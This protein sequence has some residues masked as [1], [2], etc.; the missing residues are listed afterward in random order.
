MKNKDKI[1][2]LLEQLLVEL[3]SDDTPVKRKRGRPKKEKVILP[4]HKETEDVPYVPY[5]QPKLDEIP[6]ETLQ[7]KPLK[8]KKKEQVVGT[9]AKIRQRTGRD[10]KGTAAHRQ[11]LTV[12]KGG[13]PNLFELSSDFH[14]HKDDVKIDKLLTKGKQ[15]TPRMN[16]VRTRVDVDCIG[17]GETCSVHPDEVGM[18]GRYRCMDCI[19]TGN[20]VDDDEDYEVLEDDN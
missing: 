4:A 5:V 17:C 6:L 14:A 7:K 10:K 8:R 16:A 18:E 1:A 11:Q 12:P 20:S 13:R 3:K 19:G 2:S 9:E 15:P